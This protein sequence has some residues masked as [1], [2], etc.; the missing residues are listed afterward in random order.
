MD[1]ALASRDEI[2]SWLRLTLVPGVTPKA[3]R[4]LLDV[5]KTA[6]GVAAA[7]SRELAAVTDEQAARCFAAGPDPELLGCT[8]AWLRSQTGSVFPGMLAHA[9][10]N[11]VGLLSVFL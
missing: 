1:S 3:Q 10:F 6:A 4:A 11:I 8:L 2:V 9:T 7:S 5:F